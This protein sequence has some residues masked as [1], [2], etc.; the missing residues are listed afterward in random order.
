[1]NVGARPLRLFS[2]PLAVIA[3][4]ALTASTALAQPAPQPAGPQRAPE[5]VPLILI[6]GHGADPSAWAGFMDRYGAGRVVVRS[7]YAA[8]ADKLKA[9]DL[10]KA[11]VV[12]AGYYK[13]TESGVKF[14]PDAT[15][16][17]QGSIGGCGVPRDDGLEG[18]YPI[19]YVSR[20]AR[21][22]DDVRRATG[23]DRVDLALH[24]MGNLVGRA[25]TKWHSSGAQG[26]KSKV[27]RLVCIVGPQRGINAF[28][29]T[30]DG[31]DHAGVREFMDQGELAEMC[32]EYNGWGGKSYVDQLNDGW[33]GFC[34]GAGVEYLGITATGAYGT[35]ID[36]SDQPSDHAH[37]FGIQLSGPVDSIVQ[38]IEAMDKETLGDVHI[39]TELW[40]KDPIAEIKEALGPSDGTVRF[41][42]SRMDQEPFLGAATWATFEGR[43]G[44]DDWDPEQQSNCSTF[45][46]EMAREFLFDHKL[47]KASVDSFGLRMVNAPGKQSWLVL[48]TKISGGS[49]VAAQIVEAK[50]GPE[51]FSVSN[52]IGDVTRVA[53]GITGHEISNGVKDTGALLDDLFQGHWGALGGDASQGLTDAT[54]PQFSLGGPAP[55]E[56]LGAAQGYGCP[57]AS[58]EQHAFF[59]IP[60]GAGTRR[61]HVVLY[62]PQGAVA[63]IDTIDLVVKDGAA[64]DAPTT[65]LRAVSVGID[66][67]LARGAAPAPDATGA[68]AVFHGIAASNAPASDTSVKFSFRLDAGDW[69]PFGPTATFDTPPLA[70]GEHRLS[71]RSERNCDGTVCDDAVG[72]TI[73]IFV[74]R[75]GQITVRN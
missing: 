35:Q 48:D 30:I 52:A 25:Y 16:R 63:H 8:D 42:S 74:D 9:G 20:I 57:L 72:A 23:S 65:T 6:H 49:L 61:Y 75:T 19:S 51:G 68:T 3:M 38:G 22:V 7:L 11:C 58:G 60:A 37:I 27:R 67:V 17:G 33:D 59:A 31:L 12:A 2:A 69:T 55:L 34:G 54:H 40:L 64:E 71:A 43:H 41:A 14:D 47:V 13:E 45:A 26:G 5:V 62:G 46:S 44:G 56:P 70:A 53:D 36:P 24:S 73:G 28:E 10:P 15:G 32:H 1:M 66:G 4:T 29:A 39:F 50:L 18:K 21:I